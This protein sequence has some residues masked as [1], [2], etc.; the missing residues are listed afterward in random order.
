MNEEQRRA[1]TVILHSA[2][3]VR[4]WLA[5]AARVN[6]EYE[7]SLEAIDE[8]IATAMQAQEMEDES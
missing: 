7:R 2:R 1:L 6:S 4:E 5:E 3:V 8:I